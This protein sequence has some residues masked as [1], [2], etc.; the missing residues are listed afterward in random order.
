MSGYD[1]MLEEYYEGR[2]ILGPEDG[3]PEGYEGDLLEPLGYCRNFDGDKCRKKSGKNYGKNCPE[4]DKGTNDCYEELF[5]DV[6]CP[7]IY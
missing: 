3:D 4:Y 5:L 7:W 6:C 1:E 2:D